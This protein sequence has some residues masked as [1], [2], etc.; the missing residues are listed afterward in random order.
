MN[1]MV[2]YGKNSPSHKRGTL[3]IVQ[4]PYYVAMGRGNQTSSPHL[5]PRIR[6][7]LIV[8]KAGCRDE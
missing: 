6:V 5:P 8:E 2:K 7:S 4:S 3:R 1:T